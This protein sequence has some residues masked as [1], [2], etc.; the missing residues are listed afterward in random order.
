MVALSLNEP[1]LGL[2]NPPPPM[3]SGVDETFGLAGTLWPLMYR[4]ADLLAKRKHDGAVATDAAE[5]EAVL[6]SWTV[7]DGEPLKQTTKYDPNWEAMVQIAQ[8]YK[9]TGLLVLYASGSW[10]DSSKVDLP[11]VVGGLDDA[12]QAALNSLLRVCVLSGSMCTLTWPLYT[13]A[14]HARSESDRTLLRQI[15]DKFHQRQHM[16]VVLD[17]KEKASQHWDMGVRAAG[18]SDGVF[19][20]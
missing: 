16:R 8:A 3:Q 17:A 19:L 10:H 14:M 1:P 18:I 11:S 15:F 2:L 20:A 9:Y 12:Y 4:L 5:L 6:W 13:V 7:Q